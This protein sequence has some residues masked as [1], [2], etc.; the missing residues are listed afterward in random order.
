MA[1]Q[2]QNIFVFARDPLYLLWVEQLMTILLLFLLPLILTLI[3][4]L[5]VGFLSRTDIFNMLW[6]CIAFNPL[7]EIMLFNCY[8]ALIG[9]I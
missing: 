6:I 2:N 1:C 9:V 5:P 8:V 3:I 4:A 7:E